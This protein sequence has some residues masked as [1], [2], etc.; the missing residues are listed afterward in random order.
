MNQ[1]YSVLNN[2]VD[3]DKVNA[4]STV[5]SSAASMTTYY[6]VDIRLSANSP[7]D[8]IT[9]AFSSRSELKAPKSVSLLEFSHEI[10]NVESSTKSTVFALEGPEDESMIQQNI[11]EL[12][13]AI[14]AFTS[15]NGS[16]CF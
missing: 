15:R 11:H 12:Q 13:E 6:N 16:F 9:T 10:K 2:I 4:F 14:E 7:R 3:I 8:P 5:L 1:F